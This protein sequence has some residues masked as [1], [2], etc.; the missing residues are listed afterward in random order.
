MKE[1]SLDI[2]DYPIYYGW[3]PRIPDQTED[4]C[5]FQSLCETLG[6]VTGEAFV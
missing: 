2:L 1:R 5:D 6:S 4:E 3:D